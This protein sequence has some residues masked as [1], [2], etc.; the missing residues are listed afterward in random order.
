MSHSVA[1]SETDATSVRQSQQQFV[2]QCLVE[3]RS[4]H[5]LVRR[6][7]RQQLARICKEATKRCT[8]R[9]SGFRHGCDCSRTDDC[10]VQVAGSQ[11]VRAG[12]DPNHAPTVGPW[13]HC[14]S[15][16]P[17]AVISRQRVRLEYRRD[18]GGRQRALRQII[19]SVVAHVT[20]RRFATCQAMDSGTVN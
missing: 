14:Q 15:V 8:S 3:V 9:F 1:A 20:S 4:P 10:M 17:F 18:V 7:F 13:Q 2:G 5:R 11:C 16:L 19:Y 12:K 6:V